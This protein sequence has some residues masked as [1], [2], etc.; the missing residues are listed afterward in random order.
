[1]KHLNQF[2][3]EYIVNKKLD[4]PIDSEDHYEYFPKTKNELIE[5]IKELFDNK[6]YDF[7]CIDTSEITDMSGLFYKDIFSTIAF[8]V[9][10]WNVSKIENMSGMFFYCTKFKGIGLEKWNVK[11]VKDMS[12]MFDECTSI[13]KLP[14]W[15]KK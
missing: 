9:S 5:N 6:I 13:K 12:Y 10:N 3:T 1:M 14:T 8:N 11:R 7:N 2:I 4:K 15:Y